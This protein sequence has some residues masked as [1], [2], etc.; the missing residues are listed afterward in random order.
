MD[1]F[2]RASER[3][4]QHRELSIRQAMAKN[5]PLSCSGRCLFCN[6]EIDAGKF[7]DEDC[8]KDWH[9]EQKM[10]GIMGR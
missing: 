2:D 1:D 8:N 9:F 6:T 5:Q 3:E 10:R 4:M 7:C